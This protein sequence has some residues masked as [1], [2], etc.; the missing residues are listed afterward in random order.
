MPSNIRIDV[1][2]DSSDNDVQSADDSSN[3][4]KRRQL[5]LPMNNI[6]DTPNVN[7][8]LNSPQKL[9]HLQCLS[10]CH[11]IDE[12]FVSIKEVSSNKVEYKCASCNN[13]RSTVSK[14]NLF[15][16]TRWYIHFMSCIGLTTQTK[17]ALARF[18]RAKECIEYL[19]KVNRF[20]RNMSVLT[21]SRNTQSNSHNNS[22][23][24]MTRNKSNTTTQLHNTTIHSYTDNCNDERKKKYQ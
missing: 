17:H 1:N 7:E 18:C 10:K 23:P 11:L 13:K 6:T 15:Q 19:D 9:R 8:A 14:Q 4:S 12:G 22:T 16:P 24:S 21:S 5:N 2:S 3:G 20:N